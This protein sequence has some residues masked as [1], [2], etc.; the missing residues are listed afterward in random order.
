[1]FCA[2]NFRIL[3]ATALLTA[4]HIAAQAPRPPVVNPDRSVT[5]TLS[6]PFADKV[7]VGGEFD[8]RFN[9]PP[10][11]PMSRDEKGVWTYTT[12]PLDPGSYYYGFNVDVRGSKP[13]AWEVSAGT[14][15]GAVHLEAIQSARL[16]RSA[17]SYIYTPPSCATDASRFYQAGIH[18]QTNN[19]FGGHIWQI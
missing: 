16:N 14:P 11:I 15:R 1:M 19:E 10:G 7:Y 6:A 13:F 9:R 12:Q 18:Y 3:A 5:F 2:P 4:S 8:D 17:S